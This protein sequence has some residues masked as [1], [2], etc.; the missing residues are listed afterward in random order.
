VD[1]EQAVEIHRHL[2]TAVKAIN[3]VGNLT[4]DLSKEDR[5]AFAEPLGNVVQ[6]LHYEL[7]QR[8]IYRQ[9]PDLRPPS[10][11]KPRINSKLTWDQVNLPPS[12]TVMDFDRVIISFLSR[13]WRK[14]A[15]IVGKVSEQYRSLGIDLDP[16]IAA[17]R[18]MAM[19]DSG[20]VESAG[21]LRMWRH[22][23]VRL[24]P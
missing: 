19:A 11:L 23:E 9:F 7:L 18:L 17:A 4:F 16:A 5:A 21:D 14:T 22:S 20:L 12:I 2:L 15:A 24:K 3:R 1:R 8:M 10:K 13:Y 6:T